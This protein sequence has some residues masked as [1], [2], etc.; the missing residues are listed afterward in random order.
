MEHL[1]KILKA[2]EPGEAL[3]RG[4]FKEVRELRIR[5]LILKVRGLTRVE[6]TPG[7]GIF[8]QGG[9]SYPMLHINYPTSTGLHSLRASSFCQ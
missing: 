2:R 6:D 1:T 7:A 8:I 4:R 5:D 3:R 9:N